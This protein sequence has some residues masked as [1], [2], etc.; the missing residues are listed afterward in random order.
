MDLLVQL[1]NIVAP[2]ITFIIFIVLFPPFLVFKVASFVK[3]S[4]CAEDVAGKVVL[5]TGASSGIGE[6]LA[7]EYARRG[8]NLALVARR[9]D[10]LELV[11]AKASKLGSA[12]VIT[13]QADVSKVGD[14]KRMV[15]ETM[16]QFGKC[17]F[18]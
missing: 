4:L 16:E 2:P 1:L 8:A 7:F 6:H 11:A 10:H 15:E 17:K 9:K 12:K 14:C 13:V 18:H 3:R 5:I